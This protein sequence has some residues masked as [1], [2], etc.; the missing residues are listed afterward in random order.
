MVIDTTAYLL[1]GLG[2]GKIKGK[3]KLMNGEDSAT[4]TT[5]TPAA[6]TIAAQNRKRKRDDGTDIPEQ[7]QTPGRGTMCSL[8][9]AQC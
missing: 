8:G 9:T 7:Q 4:G 5:F 3:E 2:R 6:S 1:I